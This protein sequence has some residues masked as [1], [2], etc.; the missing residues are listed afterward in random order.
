MAT[1]DDLTEFENC[2]IGFARGPGALNDMSRGVGRMLAGAGPEGA[3]L[4][5]EATA[6]GTAAADEGL[7]IGIHE[8]WRQVMKAAVAAERNSFAMKEA[9]E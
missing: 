3:A 9:A 2:Q 5:L 4:N 8:T 6:T 7:Y 1:P